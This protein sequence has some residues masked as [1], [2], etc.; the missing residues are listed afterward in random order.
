MSG[1]RTE[2]EYP[3]VEPLTPRE[4]EVLSH[5]AARWSNREIADA[6]V[7]SL[8]TVKWYARQIYAKL[9]VE[10]RQQAVSRAREL[11]LLGDT[12]PA[13]HPKHNLPAQLTPFLGRSDSLAQV[14]QWLSEPDSRLLTIVGPGGI[15][16]T[17]LAI[18]A[19]TLPNAAATGVCTRT[20]SK[21]S[22]FMRRY[23]CH[24]DLRL[25]IGLI[26]R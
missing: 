22:R 24:R 5:F 13:A 12:M 20:I 8:N 15:G 7:L 3:M 1:P 6:L 26:R 25:G 17:R 23:R 19:A 21:R 2:T 16:K 11:G 14:S 18:Q 10:G 4:M 9:G